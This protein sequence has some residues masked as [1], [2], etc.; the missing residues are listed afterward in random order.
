MRMAVRSDRV[1]RGLVAFVRGR[2][3]GVA[4][5]HPDRRGRERTSGELGHQQAQRQ[6]GAA[7]RSGAEHP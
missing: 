7:E 5:A 4:A 1:R 6:H 3:G 2:R